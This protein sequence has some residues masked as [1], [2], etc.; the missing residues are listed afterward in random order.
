MRISSFLIGSPP[1]N[2]YPSMPRISK[3]TPSLNSRDYSY[4]TIT[5][6]SWYSSDGSQGTYYLQ[7]RGAGRLSTEQVELVAAAAIAVRADVEVDGRRWQL[8]TSSSS[9]S[10][11]EWEAHQR[12]VRS[13][14]RT[15]PTV[16][17]DWGIPR[18]YT[19][20]EYSPEEGGWRD[21]WVN[22]IVVSYYAGPP[23][24]LVGVALGGSIT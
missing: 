22:P 8:R 21:V 24:T 9:C 3:V 16:V 4:T 18:P 12:S 17:E 15:H 20:R 11:K 10:Q 5:I 23:G 13:F 2:R 14:P 7:S 1:P 6:G 19:G